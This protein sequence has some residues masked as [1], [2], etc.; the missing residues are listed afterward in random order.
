MKITNTIRIL[1][2]MVAIAGVN[3]EANAEVDVSDYGNWQDILTPDQAR[4]RF[5]WLERCYS[6]VL[7][8]VWEKMYSVTDL[9]TKE[10]KISEIKEMWLIENGEQKSEPQYLTF[11]DVNHQNPKKWFGGVNLND[12]CASIP[13]D[14]R[15]SG[16]ITSFNFQEY[17]AVES[18]DTEYA[19][20]AQ[21][22]I[23][24]MVNDSTA[25]RYS[26]Y[27]GKVAIVKRN[28]VASITLTPENPYDLD[29]IWNAW[30]DWNQDGDF[31][32]IDEHVIAKLDSTGVVNAEISVPDSALLGLTKFRVNTDWVGTSKPCIEVQLG[33]VEDY[34]IK[35]Y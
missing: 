24:D 9:K 21:V 31:N 5:D 34:S 14:Y 10:Q 19:S 6:G 22:K 12:T 25:S 15:A 32:D 28:R 7:V 17:C 20:I 4:G 3:F 11:A 35:V 29:L 30:I 8:E 1:P 26:N 33:E 18:T 23:N 16:L 27:W 13:V 2:L